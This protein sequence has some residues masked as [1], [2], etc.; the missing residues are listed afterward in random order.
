[1]NEAV[2]TIV[3]EFLQ[4]LLTFETTFKSFMRKP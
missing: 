3:G 1:M 2:E 4:E